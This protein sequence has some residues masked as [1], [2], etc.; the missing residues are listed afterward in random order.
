MIRPYRFLMIL[1]SAVILTAG[2]FWIVGNNSIRTIDLKNLHHQAD[3]NGTLETIGKNNS[4]LG[5]SNKQILE[6]LQ[7]IDKKT[8]TTASIHQKL[9]SVHSGLGGQNNSLGGIQRVT[10]QQVAL[11]TDLNG[12]S[13]L[14]T[15]KMDRINTSSGS[16]LTKVRQLHSITLDTKKKMQRVLEE[17]VALEGKLRSAAEKSSRAQRSLP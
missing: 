1:A 14:L 12:L 8:L 4:L 5:V 3:L 15:A 9:R 2:G 13:Q 16:Q 17:N 10:G 7:S 11:S 6:N